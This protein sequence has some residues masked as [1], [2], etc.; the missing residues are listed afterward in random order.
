M[1]VL[2]P[3][4]ARPKLSKISMAAKPNLTY[5]TTKSLRTVGNSFKSRLRNVTRAMKQQ[6]NSLKGCLPNKAIVLENF[7]VLVPEKLK[8]L[9]WQT[10]QP[11]RKTNDEWKQLEKEAFPFA[12]F[13]VFFSFFLWSFAVF[14]LY[15]SAFF[16]RRN[17]QHRTVKITVNLKSHVSMKKRHKTVKVRCVA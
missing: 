13:L 7:P 11:Y 2:L 5:T 16:T 4:L 15:F 10:H 14:L 8:I 1:T 12:S 6:R 9:V 3:A 17:S